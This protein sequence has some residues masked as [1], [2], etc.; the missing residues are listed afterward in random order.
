MRL[1]PSEAEHGFRLDPQQLEAA[2][3]PASRLLVLNSPSNPTGM[4]LSRQELEAIAAVL[5][6]HPQVAVV[7]DEIY[8]FLLAPGH[9]APQLGR[10]GPRPEPI[11]S[12]SSTA[13]PRAGP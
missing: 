6:R 3:T 4:V 11:G 1:L 5:R 8:E 10:G 2:I 7:C 9:G 13:L 12:S